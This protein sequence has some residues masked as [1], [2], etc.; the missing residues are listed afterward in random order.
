MSSNPCNTR[1]TWL[2]TI[3][4]RTRAVYGCL[5]VGQSLCGRRLS[6]QPVGCTPTLSVTQQLPLVALYKC[7]DFYFLTVY[8]QLH[9]LPAWQLVEFK[10]AILVHQALSGDAPCYPP[11][12]WCLVTN[13]RTSRL[14]SADTRTLLVSQTCTNFCDRTFSA[15]GSRVWNY[16]SLTSDSSSRHTAISDSRWKRFY[17]VSG[18]KA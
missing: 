8:R 7:Y 6:L 16:L 5:V 1:I 15:A 2:E 12:D 14:R 17:L 10:V 18:T 4:R 11:E 13:A 9:R 3:K